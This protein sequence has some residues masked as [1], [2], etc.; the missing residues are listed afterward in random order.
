MTVIDGATDGVVATVAT[1]AEPCALCYNPINNKVYCANLC[2]GNVTVIDGASD[3]AL[4][5][6]A[7]GA[8]PLV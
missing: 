8:Q 4:M 3:S 5:T 1:G 7:V 2:G 6:L